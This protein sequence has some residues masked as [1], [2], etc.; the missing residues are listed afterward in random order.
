MTVPRRRVLFLGPLPPPYMGPTL[1]TR[2]VLASPLRE[3]FE[4]VH[5]DTSDHRDLRRLG[6]FDFTNILL[7]FL[8][9]GRL[10]KALLRQGGDLVYVPISQTTVGFLRDAGFILLARLFRRPVACHLRGGNFDVWTAGASSLTRASTSA[11][12]ALPSISVAMMI[13]SP[14]G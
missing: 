4:L 7:A 10:L 3:E 8:H 5:I 11:A 13:K 2:I 1:A 9:Y 14:G 6:A 12:M